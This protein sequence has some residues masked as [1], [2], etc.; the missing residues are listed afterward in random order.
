L[1]KSP[2]VYFFHQKSGKVVYVGK[3]R[4]L[5]DRV[6]SYFAAN[7]LP[8][9]ARMLA[10]SASITY[11]EVESEVDALLLEAN[12]IRKL[13][14][15]YNLAGKDDK[16]LPFIEIPSLKIVHKKSQNYQ[17]FGPYPPGSN[18]RRLLRFLQIQLNVFPFLPK[19]E[20]YDNLK[21]LTNFLAG[22]RKLVQRQLAKEMRTNAKAQNFEKAQNI[23]ERL[24]QI[25]YLTSAKHPPWQYEQNPNL[26]SDQR[27]NE[28]QDLQ[29]I[30]NLNKLEKIEG[31]DIANLSGK[32]ATGSQVTFI[33][34]V[35]AKKFYRRYKIRLKDT[36]DD[37]TML[38]EM[39][40][41]RLKS[42]VSLPEL[43]VIDGGR[44]Q[45]TSVR[46]VILSKHCESK[47]LPRVIG[48]AK[49]LETIYTDDGREIHLQNTSSA[50]HLLQRL[51]DE[52]HRFARRY[53]FFLRSKSMLS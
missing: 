52:A 21:K 17:Y 3:A 33:N 53:H 5:A 25:S 43:M 22:K 50:L 1:P 41:R 20:Y 19:D 40:A 24:E 16:S 6:K 46:E 14:P 18:I 48:L 36:P 45:V 26:V 31:Y 47:D 42:D 35:P 39:L 29:N 4:N 32:F 13:R 7:L 44:G 34:G 2:G 11:V 10:E 8:K 15:K 12:Y 38:A 23:K 27:G 28:I 9:T 49:R 51:R 30:L 37:Y